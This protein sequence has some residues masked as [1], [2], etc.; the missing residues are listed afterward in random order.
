MNVVPGKPHWHAPAG[1][2]DTHAHVVSKDIPIQSTRHKQPDH[3]VRVED[4]I[5]LLDGNGMAGGVQTPMSIMEPWR[6][7]LREVRPASG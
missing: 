1:A 6:Q 7:C 2:I 5:A 3:D 4:F